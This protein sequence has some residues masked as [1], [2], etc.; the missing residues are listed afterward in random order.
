MNG[1]TE[2][3]RYKVVHASPRTKLTLPPIIHFR[4]AHIIRHGSIAAVI[5]RL[6]QVGRDGAW[7]LLAAVVAGSP[8]IHGG[9][10]G[11]ARL[12]SSWKRHR[13]ELVWSMKKTALS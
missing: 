10:R 5:E 6:G 12:P 4:L 7:P 3:L 9:R 2:S 11:R 1:A 8:E 13:L